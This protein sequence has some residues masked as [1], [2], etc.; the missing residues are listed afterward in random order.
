MEHEGESKPEQVQ[1]PTESKKEKKKLFKR[2]KRE[3]G[4]PGFI[5]K[6]IIKWKRTL[7]VSRKPTGDE[8]KKSSKIT[9]IGILLLGLIGFII[10]ILYQFMTG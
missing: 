7:E 2:K 10:F 9:G 4:E 5:K 3:E 1:K 6:R 8:F